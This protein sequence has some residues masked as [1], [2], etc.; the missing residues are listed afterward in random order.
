[1]IDKR[2]KRFIDNWVKENKG[3]PDEI[4]FT[5]AVNIIDNP[6]YNKEEK[7]QLLGKIFE[8]FK[9]ELEDEVFR[10]RDGFIPE[11]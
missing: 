7:S 3:S 1:M 11:P 2:A 10:K 9:D 6:F 5:K 4:C 8:E